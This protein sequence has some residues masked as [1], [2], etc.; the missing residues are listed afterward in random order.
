MIEGLVYNKE[1]DK[2]YI[3]DLEV[4]ITNLCNLVCNQCGFFIPN[5][6]IPYIEDP[7]KEI[8]DGIKILKNLG[9][10]IHRFPILGGEP[11]IDRDLLERAIKSFRTVNNFDILEI[12]T[13]GLIP[14]GLTLNVL[15]LI[16]ELTIS[17]YFKS[18]ELISLWQKWLERQAPNVKFT[19]RQH[20]WDYQNGDYTVPDLKAQKMYNDCWY[21]KHCTTIER[22]RLFV[23]SRIAKCGSDQEGLILNSKLT[24]RDIEAFLNSEKFFPSC[25][26]C[27]PLM[28]FGKIIPGQQP[29]CRIVP[30]IDKAIKY[31]KEVLNE[32]GGKN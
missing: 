18:N 30:L 3:R 23:C 21:R 14:Q 2:Y 4:S 32:K 16:D 31:L 27:V 5:Q 11:T 6:R 17:L 20:D 19:I 28:G 13:N 29:D 1:V 26:K 22:K 10:S 7:I 12:V 9:I 15:K 24:F 25:K 8:T